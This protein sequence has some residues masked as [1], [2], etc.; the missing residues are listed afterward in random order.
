ME[1]AHEV[2]TSTGRIDDARV[3]NDSVKFHELDD[4]DH[5]YRAVAQALFKVFV[6]VPVLGRESLLLVPLQQH[7][8]DCAGEQVEQEDDAEEYEP[9]KD[10]TYDECQKR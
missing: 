5:P 6:V 3:P 10:Y 1:A 8:Y 9:G 4:V 7:E 2:P